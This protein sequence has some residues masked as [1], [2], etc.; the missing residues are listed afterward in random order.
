MANC[1]KLANCPFFSDRMASKP[2]TASIIKETYCLG[3]SS[4]CARFQVGANGLPV[5]ADLYPN[6]ADRARQIVAGKKVV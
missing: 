1:V 5:P 3:D 4:R 6:Q 2:A